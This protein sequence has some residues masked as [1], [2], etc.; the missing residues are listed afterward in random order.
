[1]NIYKKLYCILISFSALTSSFYMPTEARSMVHEE[2]L[3]N[4]NSL[5]FHPHGVDFNERKETFEFK[6][7][8]TPSYVNTA[9][10]THGRGESKFDFNQ[11]LSIAKKLKSLEIKED[12]LKILK[13]IKGI[14]LIGPSGAGKTTLLNEIRERCMEVSI[15]KRFIT[16]AAR[17]NEDDEENIHVTKEQFEERVKKGEI[18]C[19]WTRE[20]ENG[21]REHYGFEN[22][23]VGFPIYSAN[24]SLLYSDNIDE[25]INNYIIIS[26]Y[27]P[28]GIRQERLF[29]RSPDLSSEEFKV[30]VEDPY[31]DAINFA[32]VV[33]HNYGDFEKRSSKFDLVT[34]INALKVIKS[35]WG[36]I[37]DLNNHEIEYHTRLFDIVTHDVEFSDGQRKT[38]Q[39]ARRSPGIRIIV[40]QNDKFLITAEWRTEING[41]DFRLPGGKFFENTEE[42]TEFLKTFGKDALPEKGKDS[43]V[44]ELKEECG[45]A[46]RKENVEH[47]AISKC[48]A[49]VE[50]DL[51]YYFS[52]FSGKQEDF[53]HTSPEGERTLSLWLSPEEV[54]DLCMNGAISEDRTAATLMRFILSSKK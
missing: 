12:N 45:L 26:V 3:E 34:F 38:F 40:K 14:V 47:I 21:R 7:E 39:Y 23:S 43:A 48:G 42:Y 35:G 27:A 46:L 17:L 49:T 28:E 8:K 9:A 19:A 20:L 53:S 24:N 6:S 54:L 22:V 15:P 32:H 11:L 33:V 51:F 10:G 5:S 41:W 1:M 18:C 2:K 50:W 36:R 4:A 37:T 44:L 25:I 16:R 13:N 30:R 31:K 29:L 52:N